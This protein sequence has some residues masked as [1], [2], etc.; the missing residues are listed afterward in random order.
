MNRPRMG[1]AAPWCQQHFKRCMPYCS[2]FDCPPGNPSMQAMSRAVRPRLGDRHIET[3]KI[4]MCPVCG[5]DWAPRRC[6]VAS[7]AMHRHASLIKTSLAPGQMAIERPFQTVSTSIF[8]KLQ[9]P[10]SSRIWPRAWVGA[11]PAG[12]TL[13]SFQILHAQLAREPDSGRIGTPPGKMR[14]RNRGSPHPSS[15]V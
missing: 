14:K 6:A 11:S 12:M 13:S 7:C 1:T 5:R 15:L 8:H 3:C 9:R 2:H 10:G 4:R